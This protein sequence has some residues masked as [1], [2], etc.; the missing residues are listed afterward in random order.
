MADKRLADKRRI[1][2]V[3][4]NLDTIHLLEQI[5]LQAGYEP[6]LARGGEEG[7]RLLRE[8]GADL[9]LLDLVMRGVDGWMLLETVK[10]ES[11]LASIPVVIVSARHPREDP[12][13]TGTHADMFEDYFIKPFEV[14]E[15][16]ARLQELLQ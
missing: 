4:D 6:V 14:H 2:I 15:L 7:L 3:E 8:E 11:C 12:T 13:R 10:A 9:V 1:L 16:V 5:V